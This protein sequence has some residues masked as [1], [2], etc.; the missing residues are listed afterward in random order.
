MATLEGR[1][2]ASSYKDLL[3]VSNANTGIDGTPRLVSDGQGTDSILY[4]STDKVGVGGTPTSHLEII[5]AGTDSQTSLVISGY[6]DQIDKNPELVLRKSH[7]D[8]VGT[9]SATPNDTILGVIKFSGVDSSDG[10]DNGV[11]ITAEQNGSAS[12]LLPT[13][14]KF[15]TNGPT[16]A[17]TD[18]LVLHHDGGTGLGID[19]PDTLM[20][21]HKATAGGV[22]S[23]SNAQLTI[24]NNSHAGIQFLSPVSANNIIYFGNDT[25]NDVAYIGYIHSSNDLQFFINGGVRLQL[26]TNSRISLGNNDLGTSNTVFGKLA[27]TSIDAGSNYNTFIGENVADATL[28]DATYNLGIGYNALTELTSANRNVALGAGSMASIT[29]GER[30]TA[31]GVDSLGASTNADSCI[32]IGNYAMGGDNATADGTVAIGRSSL[33]L[34]TSGASNTAVGFET[35]KSATISGNSVFIGYQAGAMGSN[36]ITGGS[37]NVLIGYQTK[38]HN[39]NGNNQVVIGKSAEGQGDNSVTLGNADVTAVY[40]AQD[41][42]ATVHCAGVVVSEGINFPD[43]A[44]ANPSSDPN[45]LDNYEEGVWIA[46][47]GSDANLSLTLEQNTYTKVGNLVTACIIVTYPTTTNTSLARLT[48]PFTADSTGSSAGGAVL[49]QNMSGSQSYTACVNYS[50]GVIFRLRGVTSQTNADLSGKRLRFVIT[51]HST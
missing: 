3:Q 45:T 49:E 48:I 5:S 9:V 39:A 31:I 2:V 37:N 36:D 26:D 27:G 13:D 11:T 10:Y 23:N 32:A 30:N 25:D 18:Q 16:T 35:A 4:L 29:T 28:N 8:T 47:D 38:I 14:L 50:D 51:Y 20:H 22:N 43:D 40:M 19:N 46:T 34:L 24:E 42:G 12:T 17:N 7:S 41:S 33:S 1:S 15:V 44:S 6:N 21:I